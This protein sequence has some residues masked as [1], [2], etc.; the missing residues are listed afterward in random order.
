MRSVYLVFS[1][2]NTITSKMIKFFSKEKYSHVS[3]SLDDS[4]EYMYS[5]GRKYLYLSVIGCFNVENIHKGLYKIHK[6]SVMAIYKLNVTDNQ[7]ENVIEKI[8]NIAKSSKGYNIL[9]LLLAKFRI[10][11]N[12]NKYYCS[13]FVYNVL[14]DS[15][16]NILD[17]DNEIFK[18]MELSCIEGL[19]LLYEGKVSE[20]GL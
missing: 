12:R 10:R 3:L 4:C 2:S 16:V 7:Y 18:P 13:E 5:F 11:L 9:G 15:C 20:Y 8:N 14:S 6:D 17:K 1:H 19:E